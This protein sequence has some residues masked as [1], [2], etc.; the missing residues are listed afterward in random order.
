MNVLK[1]CTNVT[2]G[3]QMNIILIIIIFPRQNR[4]DD[5]G[6]VGQQL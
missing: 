4:E 1:C 2:V 3:N 6:G 5:K